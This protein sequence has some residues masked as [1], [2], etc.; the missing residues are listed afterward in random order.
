MTKNS[1]D[2]REQQQ[3]DAEQAQQDANKNQQKAEQEELTGRQQN[4]GLRDHQG[5]GASRSQ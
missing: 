5:T 2:P 3:R 1:T 4:D